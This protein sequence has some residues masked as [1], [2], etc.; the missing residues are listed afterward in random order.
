ML[1]LLVVPYLIPLPKQKINKVLPFQNSSFLKLGNTNVHYRVWESKSDTIENYVFLFHGFAGSTYSF[2]TLVPYLQQSNCKVVAIDLPAF[3]YSDK[4]STADFSDSLRVQIALELMNRINPNVPWI[5]VGHSMGGHATACLA[6][7]FPNKVKK[8]V[9]IDGVPFLK[10]KRSKSSFLLGIH[11]LKRWAEIIAHY[12]LYTEDKFADLLGS[13]YG[14]SPRPQQVKAYLQPFLLPGSAS[15]ILKMA[16][17]NKSISIDIKKLNEIPK[18]ILWGEND[19]WVSI[20]SAYDFFNQN[21][22]SQLQIISGAGHC[23][24]ETHPAETSFQIIKFCR[25]EN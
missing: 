22:N 24:M 2:E 7:Y 15:A 17:L 5:V 19:T 20:Q 4:S 9:F 6:H 8:L 14:V 12:F 3:G 10:I 18:L 21:K 11:P 16:S 1:L 25:N 13:A 23:P